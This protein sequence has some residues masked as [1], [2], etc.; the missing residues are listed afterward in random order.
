MAPVTGVG[1]VRYSPENGK[2]RIL[3]HLFK[4]I[5]GGLQISCGLKISRPRT[6]ER[7]EKKK[8]RTDPHQPFKVLGNIA[9]LLYTKKTTWK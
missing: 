1:E 8:K 5:E 7:R 6:R 9:P 4:P 2:M 3:R